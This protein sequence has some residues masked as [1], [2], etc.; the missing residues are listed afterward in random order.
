MLKGVQH[1]PGD[2]RNCSRRSWL[3]R[4]HG[5]GGHVLLALLFLVASPACAC[6]RDCRQFHRTGGSSR[7]RC[8]WRRVRESSH[9]FVRKGICRV[10]DRCTI[11]QLVLWSMY[12]NIEPT[13][14]IGKYLNVGPSGY[15]NKPYLV[16][17]KFMEQNIKYVFN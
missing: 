6:R 8:L 2:H 1:A 9:G 16:R 4:F 7:Q 5:H 3:H 13:A 14:P 17:C 12:S 15:V 11:M 10:P